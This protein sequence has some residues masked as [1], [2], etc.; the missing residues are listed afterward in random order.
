MRV[1]GPSMRVRGVGKNCSTAVSLTGMF[2]RQLDCA[3]KSQL[4]VALPLAQ[5]V[6]SQR[7]RSAHMERS[8]ADEPCPRVDDG[9][10]IAQVADGC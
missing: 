4:R 1:G 2:F 3:T 6:R 10:R 5:S 8:Q 9:T 7:P